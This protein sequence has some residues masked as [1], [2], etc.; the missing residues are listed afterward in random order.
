M[1]SFAVGIYH[2]VRAVCIARLRWIFCLSA[3][4]SS[5]CILFSSGIFCCV[6]DRIHLRVLRHLLQCPGLNANHSLAFTKLDCTFAK[7]DFFA[8]SH[9]AHRLERALNIYSNAQVLCVSL[10]IC[11]PATTSPWAVWLSREKG[12]T[13][14]G[15]RS[16]GGVAGTD[17]KGTPIWQDSREKKEKKTL[18][19]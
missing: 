11:D 13:A 14:P 5:R 2:D 10:T 16:V 4:H 15:C 3:K 8:E 18:A 19:V 6:L 17:T 7:L 1:Q 12:T 9:S